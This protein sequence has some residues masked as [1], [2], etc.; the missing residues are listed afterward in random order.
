MSAH[1]SHML[2]LVWLFASQAGGVLQ[3]PLANAPVPWER[4]H[5]SQP[6]SESHIAIPTASE[7]GHAIRS[8]D[9]V[10]TLVTPSMSAA[11]CNGP[12]HKKWLSNC[13]ELFASGIAVA[14]L[15]ILVWQA[16]AAVQRLGNDI[17]KEALSNLTTVNVSALCVEGARSWTGFKTP[18]LGYYTGANHSSI[19]CS[20]DDVIDLTNSSNIF[21]FLRALENCSALQWWYTPRMLHDFFADG[22]DGSSSYNLRRDVGFE[23]TSWK[24]QGGTAS[25]LSEKAYGGKTFPL[26]SWPPVDVT[27]Y[28]HATNGKKRPETIAEAPSYYPLILGV[29]GNF[30]VGID[31]NASS[32]L[33]LFANWPS[34]ALGVPCPDY[35]RINM[36]QHSNLTAGI[37]GLSYMWLRPLT[38]ATYS[39]TGH[40]ETGPWQWQL[41]ESIRSETQR[42]YPQTFLGIVGYYEDVVALYTGALGA[43]FGAVAVTMGFGALAFIKA[44]PG[45][46]HLYTRLFENFRR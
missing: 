9:G 39:C 32:A 16:N 41:W 21:P 31:L 37:P 8:N 40:I 3:N 46:L 26:G 2:Q 36:A 10:S 17:E 34:E 25:F 27:W 35:L 7:A 42:A 24:S 4:E 43:L 1:R 6:A 23:S 30:W 28:W 45:L 20:S 29:N 12:A 13:S 5:R 15:L 22:N 44:L 33:C 38:F 19:G 14:A 18:S 11:N